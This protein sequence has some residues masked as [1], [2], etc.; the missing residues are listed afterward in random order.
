[1]RR[2]VLAAALALAL[3]L[4]PPAAAAPRLVGVG[5]VA[6]N[7]RN[8]H[9][10][11][12]RPSAIRLIVIHDI[13]G[14]FAGAISWFR[15]PR[16]RASANYV[17]SRDG[18]AVQMVPDHDVAWHAGNGWVND[19]SLGIEHEGYM[20]I[21]G[22]YTDAEYRASAQLVAALVSRYR[23]PV[24]RRHL[25]G[26]DQVPD[27]FHRGRFG[28]WAHHTDPGK[29]WNWTRY[30][31]YVRDYLRGSEPPPPAFDVTIPGIE[32][33]ARLRGTV[34]WDVETTGEV[35]DH[36][37][38]LVDGVVRTTARAD[39]FELEWDTLA[40]TNGRHVLTVHAVSATGRT[41][42]ASAVVFVVNPPLPP[43]ITGET[44]TDGQTASGTLHWEVTATGR[45]DRVEFLVD[46]LFRDVE[47][48]P[49]YAFDWDTTEETPGPHTLT[50]RVVGVNGK[51]ASVTVT[52]TV[53]QPEP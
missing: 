28:G 31:G 13:E 7:A 35:P 17:V 25:I 30:L 34:L 26:H 21:A 33:A 29:T 43:T 42:D 48:T 27:P 12:R 51:A 36:M 49:P 38:F 37:D 46:G 52:V 4:V 24:D 39:P 53:A 2:A 41:A 1:V 47:F 44:V 20:G 15:N 6:A 50:A 45:I 14:T 40:E 5:F 32:L 9:Q 10:A 19:H 23:I 18:E 8:Y 22:I 3:A 16:A 11:H